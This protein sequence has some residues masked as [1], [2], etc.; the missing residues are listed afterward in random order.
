[1]KKFRRAVAA[2]SMLISFVAY[3][4]DGDPHRP[5]DHDLAASFAGLD[6]KGAKQQA[7]IILEQNPN[8]S[9]ALFVRMEVAELKVQPDVVLDSALRLCHAALPEDVLRIASGRIL[10]YAANSRSFNTLLERIEA[11]ARQQNTCASNLR[12]ALVSAAADGD[13]ALDLAQAADSAGVLTRWRIAGPFGHYSNTDFDHHWPPENDGF[14][15]TSYGALQSEEFWFRDGIVAL[16]DYFSSSG[17]YY[18]TSEIETSGPQD[19]VLEV[20]SSGPYAL[21]VDGKP[22]LTHDSRYAISSSSNS[23]HLELNAGKH[24]VTV[25]FNTD[26]AP[27]RIV[28]HAEARTTPVRTTFNA[29]PLESYIAGMAAYLGDDLPSL[30]RIS[31]SDASRAAAYL[32]A[33]LS[34]AIDE[35]SAEA[36]SAWETL[37]PA[38]LARVKMTETTADSS[39]DHAYQEI[40]KE[41]PQSEAAQ[42]AALELSRQ[43]DALLRVI[44]LHPSCSHL[45]HALRF[46]AEEPEKRQKMTR[47]LLNCA[48]E[49]LAYAKTL[50]AEGRHKDA[51]TQLI[52]VLA[53]NPLNR[54]A[55]RLLIEELLLDGRAEEA[56]EQAGRLHEIAP[57]SVD[58]ARIAASPYTA[59]DST[60]GRAEKFVESRQFYMPYRRSGLEII[61]SSANRHFSGGPSVI[62]LS[63]K[64]VEIR[65]DGS[66]SV[67]TH[68]VMRLLNKDGIAALGEV[69]IPRGANLLELRTIQ[70]NPTAGAPTIIEPELAQQKSTVSMPALEPGDSIEEEFVQHY[71]DW[72]DVPREAIEFTFGS[73]AAPILESRF[74]V[75]APEGLAVE[76]AR[77]NG[78]A[79]PQVEHSADGMILIW[80]KKNIAQTTQESALPLENQ[81]PYVAVRPVTDESAQLRDELISATRIGPEVIRAS[82]ALQQATPGNDAEKARQLFR[83]VAQRIQPANADWSANS[84]EDSLLNFEGSRTATLLALAHAVGLDADLILAR[85]IGEACGE[86]DLHCYSVPLV[87]FTLA[88]GSTLDIDAESGGAFGA[89]PSGLA[90]DWALRVP[91]QAGNRKQE[92]VALKPQAEDEKSAAEAELFL[93]E[94]GNLAVD[95]HI[96]LGTTRGQQ[97]RGVLQTANQRDRQMFFDQLAVRIFPGATQITGSSLHLDDREQSLELALHFQ[98][99]QFVHS[100]SPWEVDEMVPSLGLTDLYARTATRKLPLYLDA[101]LFESAIFHLH[102]SPGL[103]LRSLPANFKTQ[104]QFGKYSVEFTG[105]GQEVTVHREFQIPVQIISPQRYPQFVQFAREIDDAERGRIG[106]SGSSGVAGGSR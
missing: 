74:V 99:P 4:S 71:G 98:V 44:E 5:A 43:E 21:F 1:M 69:L 27:F 81:L 49:S 15:R 39:E 90:V 103:Q 18:A 77:K 65:N 50:S 79:D 45:S 91:L 68:R 101:V 102:L 34:S 11:A 40:G 19:S 78:V 63:D 58:Y 41:L 59:L 10:K 48:P 54:K 29:G 84:A 22:L 86:N 36:R 89:I 72:N 61:R 73:F 46:F 20:F 14:A 13:S 31:S 53:V 95:L 106:L 75:I 76:I 16:P 92:Y 56:A 70:A 105:G 83:F 35:H 6:L 51:A 97:V 57:N 94:S 47:Q 24:R 7:D 88:S 28:I 60:S 66:L 3:A 64:V 9:L 100:S 80:E 33:L 104:N 12:L 42:E 23:A 67:Y 8:D 62:L 85:N 55:R 38:P 93:D 26:A 17:I 37:L 96:I 87:R 30:E 32:R 25:K 52:K 2:V 82:R